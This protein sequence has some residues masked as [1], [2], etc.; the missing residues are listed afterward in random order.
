[1]LV[2]ILEQYTITVTSGIVHVR[3]MLITFHMTFS[4]V[5]R[6]P[7]LGHILFLLTDIFDTKLITT[8]EIKMD[9]ILITEQ[10]SNY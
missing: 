5:S 3:I 9:T 8:V 2:I 1:M 4:E 6:H 7:P 10:D